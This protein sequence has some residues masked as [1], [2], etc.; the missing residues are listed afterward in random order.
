ML[1]SWALPKGLPTDPKTNHL[2]VHTEDHPLEYGDFAGEIPAGEYGGGNVSIWDHGTYE[3]EKWTDREVEGG[4]ARR[5]G[6]RVATCCSR[7]GSATNWMIHRMDPAPAGTSRCRADPP[8]L[9]TSPRDCRATTTSWG[10]EFKWDGVRAIVYVDGG[11]RSRAVAQRQRLDRRPTRNCGRWPSPSG[12]RASSSTARSWRSTA[13]AGR[14]SVV[15]S[16]G[17]MSIGAAQVRRAAALTPAT[18]LAFDL[19]YLDGVSL[20]DEPYEK[21][22]ELLDELEL[23]GPSWQTPPWFRGGGAAVWEASAQQQLEGIVA[24]HLGSRYLPGKRSDTW[25]KL[26]HVRTQEVVVAGWKPGAGR[27]RRNVRLVA[28]RGQRRLRT[29]LCRSRRDRFRRARAARARYRAGRSRRRPAAVRDRAAAS[30]H[31]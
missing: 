14:R 3:R 5:P 2:A 12:R 28:P 13:T 27:R 6:I 30:G 8:M 26:K 29:D 11:R 4:V 19:L 31:P 17:C 10:Y 9:A 16:R 23:A 20:L 1:V 7:P 24:K 25:R 22:R 18:F 21:R 15:C